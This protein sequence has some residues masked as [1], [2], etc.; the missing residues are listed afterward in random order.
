MIKEDANY[1]LFIHPKKW[2]KEP[3]IDKYTR[4]MCAAM[5]LATKG[6]YYLG[7]H[8]C[9][10]G[11]AS[12]ACNYILPNEKV[13]NSLALHYLMY[14]RE[15]VPQYELYKVDKLLYGEAEPTQK[16]RE[17]GI[18][19]EKYPEQ[20]K[21]KKERERIKNQEFIETSHVVYP[22]D[23]VGIVRRRH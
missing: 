12:D 23:G 13:T 16:E 21:A 6:R 8:R 4:K 19:K 22:A 2:N 11:A 9:Y 15:D 20:E 10:C 18:I 14:H 3:V 1:I 17:P 7:Y 5:R